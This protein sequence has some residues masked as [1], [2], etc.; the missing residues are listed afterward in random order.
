MRYGHLEL[1]H[2][3]DLWCEDATAFI[4]QLAFSHRK[5]IHLPFLTRPLVA[6]AMS[7]PTH[8]RYARGFEPKY[9][10][11]Q[12]LKRRLPGYPVNQKK[13]ITSMRIPPTYQGQNRS[14]IWEEYPVP[15][16][17]PGTHQAAVKSF[18]SPLSHSALCYALL[19]KRVM[20]NAKLTR[21]PGTQVLEFTGRMAGFARRLGEKA[22]QWSWL[23]ATLPFHTGL[24]IA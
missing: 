22:R 2:W 7:V 21:V 9:L 24:A 1:A 19:T 15:D 12:A 8:E 20:R 18:Q 13:G 14:A 17:I 23:A 4:R 16:F 11:K 10:L 5:R 3:I 6:M